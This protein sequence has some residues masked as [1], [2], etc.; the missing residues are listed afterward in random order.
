MPKDNDNLSKTGIFI[1]PR[2]VG[3]ASPVCSF[4][5]DLRHQKE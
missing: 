2:S 1:Y 4:V 5:G 3:F